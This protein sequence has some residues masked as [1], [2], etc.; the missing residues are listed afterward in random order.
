MNANLT[1]FSTSIHHLLQLK[2]APWDWG[3]CLRATLC[4][5]IPFALGIYLDNIMPYM[6]VAMGTLMMTTGERKIA[7][8]QRAVGL[9]GGSVLGA[10]G[11]LL[12]YLHLLPYGFT[13]G[14][15]AGVAY[16]TSQLSNKGPNWSIGCLQLLLTASIAIGVPS[17]QHFWWPAFLYLV[18]AFIYVV[19][20]MLEALLKGPFQ[21]PAPLT[22]VEQKTPSMALTL[23][24]C[25]AIAYASKYLIHASHWFWVPL[26][27]G[28]IMKP[29]LGNVFDRSIQRC[30]GAAL[31][32]LIATLILHFFP[33]DLWLAFFLALL[34]GVLPWCMARSYIFQA[35]SLTPLVLILVDTIAPTLHNINYSGQRFID[36]VLGAIIVLVG[37]HLVAL[38]QR[39][40][41]LLTQPK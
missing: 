28:L 10:C 37:G 2:P 24:A 33:K 15:M 4:V 39:H 36:T 29:D 35:I 41:P 16:V 40:L 27:V 20:L 21:N 11:Y 14:A 30:I 3:R 22:T 38:V 25:L 34:A 18:G 7:Y 12:G 31:G 1:P 23:A 19:V 26:T 8:P 32:V 5:G 13:I 9:L 6:W 17:I